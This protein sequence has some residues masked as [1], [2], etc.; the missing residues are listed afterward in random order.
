[1][2]QAVFLL[3]VCVSLAVVLLVLL[4]IMGLM[5]LSNAV[6]RRL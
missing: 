3:A 6:G 4:P 5:A 1:M 2:K